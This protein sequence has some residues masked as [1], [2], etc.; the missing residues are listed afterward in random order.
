MTTYIP[1]IVVVALAGVLIFLYF[2]PA[3]RSAQALKASERQQAQEALA[4]EAQALA[5]RAQSL[6]DL[7]VSGDD[8]RPLPN[9]TSEAQ[10]VILKRDEVCYALSKDAQ[11]IVS[12][13]KTRYVGG[14]HG[15]SFRLAKG[16]H[17]HVGAHRG[18]PVTE[19]HEVVS[20][21][22]SVY[23]TNK[24]FIFAGSKEVTSVPVPK[25]A[26]VHLDGARV[27]VIV[28]NRVNPIVVGIT[29]PYW[30]PVIAAATQRMAQRACGTKVRSK[31][32]KR[33]TEANLATGPEPLTEIGEQ[34]Q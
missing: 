33:R 32:A 28:E 20:D 12:R 2:S 18:H 22:G 25:I 17:Y 5:A 34:E 7:F 23:V 4:A 9:L 10:G 29:Q 8:D 30:A 16:V 1:L 6:F 26:D 14:S 27:I 21:T 24:R 19:E 11:H 3:A 13:K 15:V 31:V